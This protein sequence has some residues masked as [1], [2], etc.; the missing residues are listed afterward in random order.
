MPRTWPSMRRSRVVSWSFVVVYPRS[1]MGLIIPRGGMLMS[2]PMEATTH[3]HHAHHGH[4]HHH[5][6]MP[7]EG[8]ALSVVALSATL[9][10]LTGCAIGETAGMIIGT[11]IGL[12]DW[13]TVGLAVA[14]AF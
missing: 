7:T 8:R 6:E 13:G 1:G 5:H 14:L 10:C 11:A 12:S 3:D 9:H 2:C 4:D